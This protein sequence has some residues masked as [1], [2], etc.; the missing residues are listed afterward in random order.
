M[1]PKSVLLAV[2]PIT[3][4]KSTFKTTCVFKI[5]NLDFIKELLTILA[6]NAL[7]DVPLVFKSE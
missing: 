1:I 6:L 5:V 4:P 3:A 2:L 7:M